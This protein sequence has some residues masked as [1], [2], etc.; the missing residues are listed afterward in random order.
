MD[1]E[2]LDKEMMVVE[3]QILL[4]DKQVQEVVAVKVL[5]VQMDQIPL[6][7]VELGVMD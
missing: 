1:Q 2:F 7:L 3:K 4:Q 5:L 6:F